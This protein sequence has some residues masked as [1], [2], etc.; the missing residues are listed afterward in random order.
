[1]VLT[2]SLWSFMINLFSGLLLLTFASVSNAGVDS[3]LKCARRIVQKQD[4]I[5]LAKTYLSNY[6]LGHQQALPFNHDCPS[7]DNDFVHVELTSNQASR[8]D[9]VINGFKN[10][11][12]ECHFEVL[13]AV[14]AVGIGV[15]TGI[16]AE[17]CVR[18]DGKR[19]LGV[20][21]NLGLGVGLG[22]ILSNQGSSY[23]R[24]GKGWNPIIISKRELNGVVAT[25]RETGG[26][27]IA[28]KEEDGSFKYDRENVAIGIS[29]I[30]L[31]F[32][33][34]ITEDAEPLAS[35]LILK[36]KIIPQKNDFSEQKRILSPFG[37][38]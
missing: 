7:N 34:T 30:I 26:N 23:R 36:T 37:F 29:P 20:G 16:E 15:E 19:W 10:L 9:Q 31:F 35:N 5:S 25:H 17:I 32:Y 3:A 22:A 33:S 6:L 18:S 8:I 13:S 21:I 28:V 24:K 27:L 12:Y 38:N 1:M 2:I 11:T 4:N 14:L